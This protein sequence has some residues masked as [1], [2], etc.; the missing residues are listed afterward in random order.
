[1]APYPRAYILFAALTLRR[2]ADVYLFSACCRK[3][4]LPSSVTA[5]NAALTW[6]AFAMNADFSN[7]DMTSAVVNGVDFSGANLRGECNEFVSNMSLI[8]WKFGC[9]L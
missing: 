3:L 2:V 8:Q 9:N 6:D 4:L 7:A 5:S 1:M